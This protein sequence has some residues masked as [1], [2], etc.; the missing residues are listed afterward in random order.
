[1][2][3]MASIAAPE[4][5]HFDAYI[6]GDTGTGRP[7]LVIFT[8]IFG[9]DGDMT[10][11]ADQWAEEGY[12]VAV[13]D[14]FFRVAPGVLDRSEEGRKKGFARWEKL[15]VHRTVEDMR[16][17]F[18]LLRGTPACNGRVGAIGFCAGGEFAFLAATRLGADAA[19][20]FHGTR[21]HNHLAEAHR[22]QGRISLHYGGNDPLVP[23]SEV[24]QIQAALTGNAK[25]D[26]HVY[27]GAGHGFSFKGRP[28]YHEFA[29][30]NSRSRA[31]E[32]LGALKT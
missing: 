4:G 25:A 30:T 12:L 5:T 26:I 21:I 18:A 27:D 9:L 11:V 14:Y 7:G 19:G 32:V 15:D 16:P 6:S 31:A 3:R 29:A 10:A 2:G 13:P 20:A 17:V 24:T 22:A 28:S 8:P 23:M 1:M